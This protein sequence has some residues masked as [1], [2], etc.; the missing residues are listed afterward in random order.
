MIGQPSL[1]V[2]TL[3]PLGQVM[4][5]VF[6]GGPLGPSQFLS[7]SAKNG[8]KRHNIQ[9]LLS[10]IWLLVASSFCFP[11][12]GK[13]MNR[14][15]WQHVSVRLICFV[16]LQHLYNAFHSFLVVLLFPSS[17]SY[18]SIY[19]NI[20]TFWPSISLNVASLDNP[21]SQQTQDVAMYLS[22]IHIWRCRRS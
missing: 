6:F 22:L 9:R 1:A 11:Q 3:C 4:P 13:K 12:L 19:D 10:S 14:T 7:A 15:I 18:D 17:S 2:M 16:F 21:C 20:I 5:S 8:D